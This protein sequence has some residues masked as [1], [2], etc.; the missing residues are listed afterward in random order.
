MSVPCCYQCRDLTAT[1]IDIAKDGE[2]IL[3]GALCERCLAVA[4]NEMAEHR[5]EFEALLAAGVSRSDANDMMIA[6]IDGKQVR[7]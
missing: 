3:S 1:P 6:K 2:I 4:L 5:R 7:A